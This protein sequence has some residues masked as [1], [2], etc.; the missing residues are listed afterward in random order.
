MARERESVLLQSWWGA[1]GLRAQTAGSELPWPPETA[2][3]CLQVFGD[4]DADGFYR[5]EGGGRMGYIPCNMVVEVAV[6]SPA[7]RQQLLQRGYLSPD[8]LTEGSGMTCCR[9]LPTSH[10][11]TS[12]SALP[13]QFV[14]PGWPGGLV[15]PEPSRA[16]GLAETEAC[17]APAVGLPRG[18]GLCC[19]RG[20]LC[21]LDP[22]GWGWEKNAL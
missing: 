12:N 19:R 4:K 10:H 11:A 5:G 7:E 1:V 18:T 22:G 2:G 17:V 13:E 15:H 16:C 9:P 3:L 6:A 21:S 20:G 14:R 8:V